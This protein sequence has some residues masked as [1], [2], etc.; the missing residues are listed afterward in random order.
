MTASTGGE[1]KLRLDPEL[2]T[3]I[4]TARRIERSTR[5][6]FV[7]ATVLRALRETGTLASAH[8]STDGAG[9]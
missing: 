2:T 3:A 5:V 7:R 4:D 8:A 6:G 9:R 1:V